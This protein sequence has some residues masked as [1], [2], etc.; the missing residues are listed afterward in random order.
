MTEGS[1]T[2]SGLQHALIG[3]ALVA[4][5][6]TYGVRRMVNW[7]ILALIAVLVL[8]L[9]FGDL[10]PGLT[11]GFMLVSLLILGLPWS[12]TQVVMAPDARRT[13]LWSSLWR[14]S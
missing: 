7:P 2:S 13:S 3:L 14:R 11:I 4:N 5:A 8:N 12:F 9:A 1:T 6:L 10:H